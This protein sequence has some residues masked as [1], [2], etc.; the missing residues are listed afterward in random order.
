MIETGNILPWAILFSIIVTLASA[1]M[2]V[3]RGPQQTS[4]AFSGS[5]LP[6]IVTGIIAGLEKDLVNRQ[7]GLTLVLIIALVALLILAL[8]AFI[9]NVRKR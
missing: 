1:V 3:R 6:W 8:A 4:R 7:F 2:V 5:V 9:A